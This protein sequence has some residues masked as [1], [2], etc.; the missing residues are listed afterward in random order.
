MQV[1]LKLVLME[2][3]SWAILLP[4]FLITVFL[5][6]LRPLPY[7][8]DNLIGPVVL[9]GGLI[10]MFK[11]NYYELLKLEMVKETILFTFVNRNSFIAK[12]PDVR[13]AIRD[14][15]VKREDCLLRLNDH[16]ELLI[17]VIRRNSVSD[18]IWNGVV[19]QLTGTICPV[20]QGP[21]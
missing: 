11:R 19:K 5:P 20:H 16:K 15:I 13:V 1:K 6:F 12:K 7:G 4:G 3:Q 21:K 2:S 8:L 17:A 10:W 14:I 18:T 9:R